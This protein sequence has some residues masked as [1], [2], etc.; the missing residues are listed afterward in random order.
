MSESTSN[1]TNAT[2]ICNNCSLVESAPNSEQTASNNVALHE[3]VVDYFEHYAPV[4]ASDIVA[5]NK[6]VSNRP[7]I[8]Q[9]IVCTP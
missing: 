1:E 7:T 5:L 9:R 8:R 2:A 4:I 6:K 3:S